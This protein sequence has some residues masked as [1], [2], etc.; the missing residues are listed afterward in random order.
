MGGGEESGGG[1]AGFLKKVS[2][3]TTHGSSWRSR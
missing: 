2:G 3:A 1:E